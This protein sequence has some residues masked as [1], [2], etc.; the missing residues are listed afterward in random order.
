MNI[1]GAMN[2]RY[3]LT[4]NDLLVFIKK[5]FNYTRSISGHGVRRTLNNAKELIP[6]LEI[7]EVPT[8]TNIWD[9]T[10]PQEWVFRAARILNAKGEIILDAKN[11]NLHVVSYSEPVNRTISLEEL[12]KNLYSMPQFPDAIPYKTSYYERRWGFCIEDKV[13]KQLLPGDYQV[14]IDSSFVDGSMTLGQIYIPGSVKSEILFSTYICHPSMANNELSGPAIA[15]GLASYIK[16]TRNH[17]SYRILFCPETI[18]SLYF[19]SRNLDHLKSNL[20]AGYV[21]TCLGDE[22]AW[23]YMP[24][25][26][27]STLSDKIA[28][29]VLKKLNIEYI[30]NSFLSRGSDERQYCSPNIDLPV[31]SVMRSKYGTYPEYHTSK[32]DINFIS[33]NG[34]RDS[35]NFYKAVIDEFESNKIPKLKI[36]GEPM[37]SKRSLRSTLGG[38]VL[39]QD[40]SLI[41]NIIAY[42][43]GTNDTT[44]MADLFN[45][46]PTSLNLIFALLEKNEIISFL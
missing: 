10:V 38:S 5:V 2:P 32:D 44:E 18:G 34:L 29:R 15:L 37:L 42:S 3:I 7:F 12:Q 23:N 40:E 17:Y 31:C 16:S 35:L 43:D 27:G 4:A 21:L 46:S 26:T 33:E 11:N 1:G 20:I 30:L 9:W 36:F 45:A 14:L 22:L 13:R 6:E 19:L 24:S 39:S 25:R 41:S 28:K 8:G